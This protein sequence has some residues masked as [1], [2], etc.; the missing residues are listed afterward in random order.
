MSESILAGT[1]NIPI[2][3]TIKTKIN[4]Y[5]DGIGIRLIITDETGDTQLAVEEFSFADVLQ[6]SLN[7]MSP[8]AQEAIKENLIKDLRRFANQVKKLKVTTEEK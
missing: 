7:D 5:F 8:G 2:V 1:V 6:N 3:T 4:L